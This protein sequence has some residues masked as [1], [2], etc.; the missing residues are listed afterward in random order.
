MIAMTHA[1]ERKDAELTAAQ[2][3]GRRVRRARKARN[4]STYDLGS[5]TGMSQGWVSTI[6]R[7]ERNATVELADRVAR[8]LDVTVLSLLTPDG[9]CG[10]CRDKPPAGYRCLSCGA[11]TPREGRH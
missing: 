6:E 5:L 8:A 10:N 1:D 2:S 11:D 7:A 4:L 9:P 3:F